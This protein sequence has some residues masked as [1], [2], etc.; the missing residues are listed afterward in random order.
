MIIDS[1][2]NLEK[3][4]FMNTLFQKAFEFFGEL[5]ERDVPDGKYFMPNCP[6]ENGVYV[7]IGTKALTEKSELS[8]EAHKK[9]IDVQIVLSGTELMCVPSEIQPKPLGEY[10]CE[11]DCIMYEPVSRDS[12]HCLRISRDS[13][14][15]FMDGEL[16]IPEVAMCGD[17]KKVRKAIIKVLAD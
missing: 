12:C 3:Y 6:E 1:V 4:S 13:F 10:S 5:M 16:H 8:A 9:Y 14:A 15:I 2:K 7:I 17:T 11:K